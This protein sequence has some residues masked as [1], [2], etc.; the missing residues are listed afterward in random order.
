MSRRNRVAK[1]KAESLK[2]TSQTPTV[3]TPTTEKPAALETKSPSRWLTVFLPIAAVVISCASFANSCYQT[4]QARKIFRPYVRPDIQCVV[5]HSSR[6]EDKDNPLATELVVWNNGPIKAVSVSVAY[7]SFIVDLTT[8][9]V[10]A[11]MSIPEDL[12]DATFIQADLEVGP[13]IIRPIL[14]TSPPVVTVVEITYYR[15]SDMKKFSR[16]DFF[17]NDSGSYYD[18]QSYMSHPGYATLM[19]NLQRKMKAEAMRP[20]DGIR[21]MPPASPGHVNIVYNFGN[22]S[23]DGSWTN[24]AGT[25]AVTM[26]PLGPLP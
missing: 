12:S 26:T 6:P 19:K 2:P 21:Q 10:I 5:R 16:E 9:K 7:K 24:T 25:N 15:E 4:V 23:D 3:E 13:K 8:L 22:L 14:G 17:F 20:M 18:Q 11:S 1:K